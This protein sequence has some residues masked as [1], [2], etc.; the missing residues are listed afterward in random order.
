MYTESFDSRC[1]LWN[2]YIFVG[3][4]DMARAALEDP[5]NK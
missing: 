1:Y 4:S 5:V 3:W 2:T